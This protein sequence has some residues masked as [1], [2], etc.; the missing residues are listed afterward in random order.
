MKRDGEGEQEMI[1]D[2]EEMPGLEDWLKRSKEQVTKMAQL[3][4]DKGRGGLSPV[5]GL[6]K[7]REK[8]GML[9]RKTLYLVQTE[10]CWEN[11]GTASAFLC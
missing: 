11:L 6:E 3:H 7:F 1:L 8:R 5:P 2:Q 10:G 4:S 9:T